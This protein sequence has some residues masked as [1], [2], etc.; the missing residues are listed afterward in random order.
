MSGAVNH[1]CSLNDPVYTVWVSVESEAGT[2]SISSQLPYALPAAANTLSE[3]V[4]DT[5]VT[6]EAWWKVISEEQLKKPCYVLQMK[7]LNCF[8]LSYLPVLKYCWVRY[9]CATWS[10]HSQID[11]LVGVTIQMSLCYQCKLTIRLH[12]SFND[13]GLC[14]IK[15]PIT[16]ELILF[17][18]MYNTVG[19]RMDPSGITTVLTST[20]LMI[21][22]IKI[23]SFNTQLLLSC[24]SFLSLTA[25][26]IILYVLLRVY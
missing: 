1:L 8:V 11:H 9:W 14:G 16:P 15:M 17:T 21:Q 4:S 13:K 6:D 19:P 18:Y 22:S 12:L 7:T 5:T 3:W 24:G 23:L 26:D 10:S 20:L 2:G 25:E